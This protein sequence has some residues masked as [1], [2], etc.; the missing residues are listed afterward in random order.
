VNQKKACW[1]TVNGEKQMN[2]KQGKI[3]NRNGGSKDLNKR[4]K[5]TNNG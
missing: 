1:R 2:E 4:L 5:K 3:E